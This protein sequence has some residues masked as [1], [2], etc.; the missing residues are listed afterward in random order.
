MTGATS[1]SSLGRRSFVARIAAVLALAACAVAIYILV[2]GFLDNEDEPKEERKSR[3][4]ET[5]KRASSPASYT[6][7]P[8]DTLLHIADATGVPARKI[9]R[10]NPELD[11]ET[12]NAGQVLTLR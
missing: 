8:G 9:E 4:E 2:T 7:T 10:L 6:V 5:R 3:S 12:I 1:S 11:A